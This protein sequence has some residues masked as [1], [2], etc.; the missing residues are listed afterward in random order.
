MKPTKAVIRKEIEGLARA[1]EALAYSYR[2]C[3]GIGLRDD[4]SDEELESYEAFTS[5]FARLSDIII[6]K[7][8]RLLD[9][10]NLEDSGTVRDRINRAEKNAYIRSADQFIEIR[11]LRNEIS[12]VY[13][14]ETVQDI[15]KKVIEYSSILLES[16]DLIVN[17]LRKSEQ[18]IT[19]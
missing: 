4:L 5:R 9:L 6:Q 16:V 19:D 13:R 10:I 12:H 14:S 2:K 11:E 18:E 15:F 17:H 3:Q 8:L 7:N 1:S